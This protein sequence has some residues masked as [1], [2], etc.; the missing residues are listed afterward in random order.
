VLSR[1]QYHFTL[2][3]GTVTRARAP[4]PRS[5]ES[6]NGCPLVRLESLTCL[7]RT[8]LQNKAI[9][10][11]RQLSRLDANARYALVESAIGAKAIDDVAHTMGP[12]TS[13]TQTYQ[14]AAYEHRYSR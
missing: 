9:S 6:T 2:R 14:L 3:E 13:R 7:I 10:A 11:S 1:E 8:I 12:A 5:C 4:S